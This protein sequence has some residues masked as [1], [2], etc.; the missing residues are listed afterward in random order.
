M[1]TVWLKYK[2][3]ILDIIC[4]HFPRFS[5]SSNVKTKITLDKVKRPELKLKKKDGRA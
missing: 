2:K 3:V 1:S 4:T 5:E